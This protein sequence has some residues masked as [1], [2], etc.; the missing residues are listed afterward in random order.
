MGYG[1]GRWCPAN[2]VVVD[3]GGSKDHPLVGHLDVSEEAI[4]SNVDESEGLPPDDES[5]GERAYS[6]HE[7]YDH[8]SNRSVPHSNADSTYV[9][10]S[11]QPPANMP[12]HT[13]YLTFATLYPNYPD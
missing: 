8:K 4:G 5:L 10:K 6:K 1:P 3:K 7:R 12:G 11:G 9:F 13:G 2:D